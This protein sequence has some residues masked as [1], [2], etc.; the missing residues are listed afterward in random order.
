MQSF[1]LPLPCSHRE[2]SL[3]LQ[4]RASSRKNAFSTRRQIYTY[5]IMPRSRI[6]EVTAPLSFLPG[7]QQ[8]PGVYPIPGFEATMLVLHTWANGIQRLDF[9]RALSPGLLL[10]SPEVTSIIFLHLRKAGQNDRSILTLCLKSYHIEIITHMLNLSVF[11]IR[12]FV[13]FSS[14]S[15]HFSISHW[16]H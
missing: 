4:C 6:S 16:L 12:M 14:Y 13:F 3:I 11:E 9:S 10:L 7:S 8:L 15:L 5:S 1:L 2:A